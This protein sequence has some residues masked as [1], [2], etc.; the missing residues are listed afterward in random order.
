MEKSEKMTPVGVFFCL[1]QASVLSASFSALPALVEYQ[2]GYA[3]KTY[4]N[5]CY[6]LGI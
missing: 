5:Y 1:W 4:L 6:L 3:I 2:E